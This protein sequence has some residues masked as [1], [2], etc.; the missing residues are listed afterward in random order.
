MIHVTEM[1]PEVKILLI[2]IVNAASSCLRDD[3]TCLEYKGPRLRSY[4]IERDLNALTKG[5]IPW[6]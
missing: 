5:K 4:D 2:P 6:S 3:T 1:S